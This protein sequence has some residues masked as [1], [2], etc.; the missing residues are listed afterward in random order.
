VAVM[1]RIKGAAVDCDFLQRS[2]LNVQRS[3][4]NSK[5]LS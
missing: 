1:N 5:C 4:F 2:M 3:T